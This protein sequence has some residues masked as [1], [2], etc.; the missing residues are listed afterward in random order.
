VLR[1]EGLPDKGDI[2]DYVKSFISEWDGY[3]PIAEN[4]HEILKEELRAELKKA[5]P[6]PDEWGLGTLNTLDSGGYWDKLNEIKTDTPPVQALQTE[7]IPEP[8]RVWLD[9]VSHRMQTPKDFA[10]ISSLVI[11][12]SL[13]GAGCAIKPKRF[14]DWQVIP[15][16][17]GACIGRP[18][19]VLKTPSMKE[20]MSLLERLQAEYGELYE[21]DKAGG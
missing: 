13:I 17:W 7:L 12:G 6:V 1:L 20:P 8:F 2:V 3:T 19:V 15:N 11:T 9:D 10:V 18:S 5:V 14:D 4:L 21:K 16:V